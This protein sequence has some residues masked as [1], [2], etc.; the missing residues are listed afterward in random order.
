MRPEKL[1][2]WAALAGVAAF[3][4]LYWE[5]ADAHEALSAA[6]VTWKYD[7]FC[8]NGDSRTGDCQMIP[9]RSVKIVKGGFEI[10]LKPGD[11]RLIT[12]RHDFSLPQAQARRSKD[13]DYHLC[14]YP[15]EDTLRCFYAPDMSY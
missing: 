14:L 12:R 6:G 15:T 9:A 2:F 4:A 11:H 7:G 1:M 3:T 8:C 5:P 13:E 10:T